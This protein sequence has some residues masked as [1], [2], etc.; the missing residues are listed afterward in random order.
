MTAI[1]D[2]FRR[3]VDDMT[4]RVHAIRDDQWHRPTPCAGWDVRELV[5]HVTLEDLQ[6]PPL[7]AGLTAADAADLLDDALLVDDPVAAW[8]AAARAAVDA[9][10]APSAANRSV[11]LPFGDVLGAEYAAEL[12]ADLVIHSWDLA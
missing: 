11:H 9:F 3:A 6:V 4:D 12:V 2:H 7:L 5:D 8:D 1:T 10:S